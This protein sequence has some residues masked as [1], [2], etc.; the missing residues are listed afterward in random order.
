MKNL[1]KSHQNTDEKH[2]TNSKINQNGSADAQVNCQINQVMKNM[3]TVLESVLLELHQS[4]EDNLKFKQDVSNQFMTFFLINKILVIRW[5]QLQKTYLLKYTN[6]V[7]LWSLKII[8]QLKY[9]D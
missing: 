1:N 6:Y 7:C 9:L 8:I 3:Q 2:E 5:L 4:K